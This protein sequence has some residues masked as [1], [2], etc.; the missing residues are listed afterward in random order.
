MKTLDL[1][2]KKLDR[3][4][5]LRREVLLS[6]FETIVRGDTLITENGVPVLAYYE[7][8]DDLNPFL[9]AVKATKFTTGPRTL[10]LISTSAIFGYMPR[11]TLR[12]DYCSATAMARNQPAEHAV[13][14]EH[15]KLAAAKYAAAFPALFA[16]HSAEVADKVRPEYILPGSPFT[17]GIIN[18]NNQLKYHLDAGNFPNCASCM[19]AFKKNVAGGYLCLPEFGVALEIADRSLTIFDGQGLLHGV[20]PVSYQSDDA[21]RYSVVYYSLKQMWKCLGTAG[22]IDRIRKVKT[23]RER[24]RHSL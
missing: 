1:K 3:K 23:D 24:K 21:Y 18:K 4:D 8:G 17:S 12:A 15:A 10:G 5:W 13:I 9:E 22:E 20:T 7:L 11:R 14:V 16:A 6:D 19:F 2:R